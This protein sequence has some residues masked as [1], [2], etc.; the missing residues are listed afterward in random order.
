MGCLIPVLETSPHLLSLV[1]CIILRGIPRGDEAGVLDNLK[2]LVSAP[3]LRTLELGFAGRSWNA[4]YFRYLLAHCSST[5]TELRLLHCHDYAGLVHDYALPP[6][7]Q[8]CRPLPRINRLTLTFSSGAIAVLN[9][10]L[11]SPFLTHMRHLGYLESPHDSLGPLL[12]RIGQNVESLIVDTN[13]RDA[14]GLRL[15]QLVLRKLLSLRALV[16][17]VMV[18]TPRYETRLIPP[19]DREEVVRAI[20][21]SM[22]RLTENRILSVR[23]FFEKKRGLY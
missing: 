23:F 13:V 11:F 2:L 8:Q 6:V 3:D 15:E 5:L 4:G 16:M 18:V 14:L 21:K 20:E 7:T 10:P 17:E 22:P 9:E 12:C 19:L 1:R